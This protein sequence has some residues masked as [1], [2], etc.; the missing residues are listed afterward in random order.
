MTAQPAHHARSHGSHDYS[1]TWCPASLPPATRRADACPRPRRSFW[2]SP[3]RSIFLHSHY[4][5]TL[6]AGPVDADLSDFATSRPS[7]PPHRQRSSRLRPTAPRPLGVRA[8]RRVLRVP[9]PE[10]RV[11]APCRPGLRRRGPPRQRAE[12]RGVRVSS[13]QP[14]PSRFAGR[15]IAARS[16]GSSCS[17]RRSSPR[18]PRCSSSGSSTSS[19][20]AGLSNA[21]RRTSASTISARSRR[22]PVARLRDDPARRPPQAR[23]SGRGRRGASASPLAA[24]LDSVGGMVADRGRGVASSHGGARRVGARRVLAVAAICLVV[25][26]AAGH[27]ARAGD[28]S[29]PRV[30]RASHPRRS[31]RTKTSR[32]TRTARCSA[33]SG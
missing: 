22:C 5:P 9:R 17:G 19:R 33:T 27:V 32:H 1:R 26:T 8:A 29:V 28:R 25:T 21:S 2:R 23:P 15:R 11:G 31:W 3:F 4:Q 16:S 18:S 24:A 20:A 10:H 14:F 7:R 30:P 6:S 12:V 13:P